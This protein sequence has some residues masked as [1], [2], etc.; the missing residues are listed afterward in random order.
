MRH[1]DDRLTDRERRLLAPLVD[2]L[3]L[4]PP[5]ELPVTLPARL[6]AAFARVTARI[7]NPPEGGPCM[8]SGRHETKRPLRAGRR[9]ADPNGAVDPAA[10]PWERTGPG[11]HAHDGAEPHEDH[12]QPYGDIP[13][14]HEDHDLVPMHDWPVDY[15]SDQARQDRTDRLRAVAAE[16]DPDEPPSAERARYEPPTVTGPYPV[17]PQTGTHD[18]QDEPP[19]ETQPSTTAEPA[20]PRDIAVRR[21]SSVQTARETGKLPAESIA[22]VAADDFADA[23]FHGHDDAVLR[24]EM[25]WSRQLARGVA[26]IMLHNA[27]ERPRGGSGPELAPMELVAN[28]HA[29]AEHLLRNR[30]DNHTD[31]RAPDAG[32]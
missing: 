4:V 12:D 1:D 18:A 5:E 23:L 19:T 13:H 25:N 9:T 6:R 28:V 26:R 21:T 7:L 30:L 22:D 10:P 3:R 31:E 11:Q 32:D 8:P 2:A 16:D 20:S 17:D 27:D 15:A 29:A 24:H 14:Y